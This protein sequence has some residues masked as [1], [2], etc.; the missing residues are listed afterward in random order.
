MRE[1]KFR[2][3]NL[4]D[5]KMFYEV[6]DAF[7]NDYGSYFVDCHGFNDV[8]ES[9]AEGH[10]IL[11]QF[12]GLKDKHSKEI[13]EGDIVRYRSD[14]ESYP[15]V[16]SESYEDEVIFEAPEFTCKNGGF[17]LPFEASKYEVIGFTTDFN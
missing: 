1:I 5:K 16:E 10:G 14:A 17:W 12:T 6:Q 3:W 8:L 15:L 9:V 2:L 4:H 7:H 11:M 13:Y